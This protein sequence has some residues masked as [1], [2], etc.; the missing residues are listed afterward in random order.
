MENFKFPGDIPY[1]SGLE[2]FS[3]FTVYMVHPVPVSPHLLQ[4]NLIN[5]ESLLFLSGIEMSLHWKSASLE[6][7]VSLDLKVGPSVKSKSQ[8]GK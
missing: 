2:Y 6:A 1:F 3:L 7:Q 8:S 4:L 5:N